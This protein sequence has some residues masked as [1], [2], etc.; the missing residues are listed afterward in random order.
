MLNTNG[1]ASL[2]NSF[3]ILGNHT[4][5][6]VYNGAGNFAGSFQTITEQVVARR[7]SRTAL[8]ASAASVTAGQPVSVTVTISPRSGTGVPTGTITFLDGTVDPG[9]VTLRGGKSILTRSFATK[10][11]RR[12]NAV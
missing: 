5:K 2:T 9:K 1:K 12:F 6:A 3:S 10:G 4:I 8:V 7:S 11:S